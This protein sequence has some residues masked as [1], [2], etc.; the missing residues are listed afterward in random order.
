MDFQASSFENC[1]FIGDLNS[2]WFRGNFPTVSLKKEFGH[3]K[4]N[5]MFNVSF[6]KAALRDVTFS[7]DCDLSTIT[8]PHK[9]QYLFFNNWNEQL[10]RIM[11]KVQQTNLRQQAT[12][13]LLLSKYIKFIPKLK[14]TIS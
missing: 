6:E 14:N 4:Q 12:I 9:G 1:V 11:K 2:V 13:L 8:L 3:A 5:K 10:N 7:D